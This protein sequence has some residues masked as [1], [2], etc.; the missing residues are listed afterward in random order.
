MSRCGGELDY[1]KGGVALLVDEGRTLRLWGSESEAIQI[2]L[3]FAQQKL[4][5]TRSLS[6]PAH[7]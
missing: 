7:F 5:S 4:G 3:R 6:G 1:R 2:A